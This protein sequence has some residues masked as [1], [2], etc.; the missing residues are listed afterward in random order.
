VTTQAWVLLDQTAGA[1]TTSGEAMTPAAM[2]Y[3]REACLAQLNGE[4]REEYGGGESTIRIG[5]SP[6]DVQTGE[7]VFSIEPTLPVPGASAFHTDTGEGVEA[8]YCAITTCDTLLG[9]GQ[10][11]IVDFSHELGEDKADPGCNEVCDDTVGTF[12][13][14]EICDPVEL[15]TYPYTCQDGTV[16]YLSNFVLRSFF[17]PGACGPYD[18]MC[19]KGIPGAVPPPGPMQTAPG[20]GGN[21]QIECPSTTSEE[22][23]VMGRSDT[24]NSDALIPEPLVRG[25]PRITGTRRKGGEPHWASRAAKRLAR[26]SGATTTSPSS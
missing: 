23:Q 20:N 18:Y 14:K 8:A 5:S 26:M 10:S 12:H 6:T 1:T 24:G 17:I 11:V 3:I 2:G 22:Q 4:L 21:Y 19:S 16:V 25:V 9:A 13:A 7:K 15:Q